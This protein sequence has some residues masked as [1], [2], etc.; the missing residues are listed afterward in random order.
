MAT[1]TSAANAEGASTAAADRHCEGS[2][3][4]ARG[5]AGTA[6][7]EPSSLGDGGDGCDLLHEVLLAG[8]GAGRHS[9]KGW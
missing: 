3:H 2:G 1:P 7:G 4:S 8:T 6:E 5:Q 9:G